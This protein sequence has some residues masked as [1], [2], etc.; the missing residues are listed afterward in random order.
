MC[1]FVVEEGPLWVLCSAGCPVEFYAN[2]SDEGTC[3]ETEG[4]DTI[5][6]PLRVWPC[7]TRCA[8]R[9]FGFL[10]ATYN[11][12]SQHSNVHDM[13]VLPLQ[14]MVQIILTFSMVCRMAT[15]LSAVEQIVLQACRDNPNVSTACTALLLQTHMPEAVRDWVAFM[16]GLSSEA[17]HTATPDIDEK[18][19]TNA[20]NNLLNK[21]RLNIIQYGGNLSF[22]Y[23]S[24]GEALK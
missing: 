16:Q 24:E 3:I 20:L 10:G 1:H 17:L 2:T 6:A 7:D 18:M 4:H 14:F 11:R 22:H 13:P 19:V 9:L 15:K 5:T 21:H 23:I 12:K 8:I